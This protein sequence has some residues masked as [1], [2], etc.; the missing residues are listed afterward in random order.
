VSDDERQTPFGPE[1]DLEDRLGQLG[2]DPEMIEL[3]AD[4]AAAGREAELPKEGKRLEQE[5]QADAAAAA[6]QRR[7]RRYLV[8]ALL[9]S[10][11]FMTGLIIVLFWVFMALFSTYITQ[12]PTA[13]DPAV[14]LKAPS[15]QHWFGT[16]DLGRD[17]FARTMAGARTVLIIAP[18]ATLLALLWG[19]IIGLIAGFY[20]GITDE[21]VMR[22]IDVLLAL[23]I[24]ITSILILSLLGKGTAIIIVAIGALFTPVV[25]RTVR[26]AVIGEREREYVMAARLR[27][28]RSAFVMSREILPNITQ[29]IIVEGTIRLGYAVFT[30]A[31]LSFLGFGLAPPSPDWGLTIAV[32][33]VFLQIAPWTVLF[34]AAALASLVVAV[35]LITDGLGR[36]FSR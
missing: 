12:S 23:P 31:T 3:R 36:T 15:P 29:P 33:R 24:I 21:I 14:S 5:L 6:E 34:P 8:K 25:S 30:A 1:P 7:Q 26:A 32:E 10:P 16:D 2:D 22:L 13:T 18:L 17:V 28:E 20:R 4:A 9:R 19:G 27:G 11:T 35:N